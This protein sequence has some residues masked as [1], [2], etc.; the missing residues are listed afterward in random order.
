MIATLI[1]GIVLWTALLYFFV[2]PWLAGVWLLF[3]F[4]FGLL[5]YLELTQAEP[6]DPAPELS[7][8]DEALLCRGRLPRDK[9]YEAISEPDYRRAA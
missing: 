9:D 1:L 8:F 5:I 6:E 4:A 3:I 7:E 2:A